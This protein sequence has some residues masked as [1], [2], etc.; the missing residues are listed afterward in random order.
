[1]RKLVGILVIVVLLILLVG[2]GQSSDI[3]QEGDLEDNS[4]KEEEM[5]LPEEPPENVNWISPAKVEVGNFYPGARAECE[6]LVHN[7]NDYEA[8]F[9][10]RYRHP[11]N[12]KDDY[13]MPTVEAEGWVFV[14]DSPIVLAPYETGTVLIVLEM[15][16][17]AISP[18]DNWEFW[19][20]AKDTTQEGMVMVELATRW[21]V[22]MK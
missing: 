3:T 7:G 19:V 4:S 10:V 12:V 6:L 9:D 5:L 13:A 1:M 16:E 22:H 8:S 11:D 15:P 20:S 14:I 18:G 21:L 2:C 17:D